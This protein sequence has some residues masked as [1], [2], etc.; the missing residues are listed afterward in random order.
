MALENST[1]HERLSELVERET[2]ALK[3]FIEGLL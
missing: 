1:S 3:K 2:G